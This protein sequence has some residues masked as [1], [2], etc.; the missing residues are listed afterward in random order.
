MKEKYTKWQGENN[1]GDIVKL[2]RQKDG[3]F[4]SFCNTKE[5]YQGATIIPHEFF[6]KFF[7]QK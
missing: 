4:L 3:W 1:E 7:N 6:D 2:Q 5:G